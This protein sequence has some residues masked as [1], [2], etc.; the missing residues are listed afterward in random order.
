L[1]ENAQISK[2]ACDFAR[3]YGVSE[4]D[5][6]LYGGEEYELIV[7]IPARK[8]PEAQKA[9][10]GKLA[11][12]GVVTDSFRGVRMKLGEALVPVEKKGWEHFRN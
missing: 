10:K 1:V 6:A 11:R 4:S 12:I 9:A 2:S 5:L 7:T 8:F 3:K